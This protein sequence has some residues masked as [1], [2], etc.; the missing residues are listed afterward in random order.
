M[1]EYVQ[2]EV[3]YVA[4][5]KAVRRRVVRVPPFSSEPLE[6]PQCMNELKQAERQAATI[7]EAWRLAGWKVKAHVVQVRDAKG[8]RYQVVTPGLVNG[9]PVEAFLQKE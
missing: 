1:R 4:E 9:L 5:E 2:G 7:E 3:P 8:L 6:N